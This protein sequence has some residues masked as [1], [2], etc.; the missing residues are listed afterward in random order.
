LEGVERLQ[1]RAIMARRMNICQQFQHE[2]EAG[3]TFL[4]GS[5][6]PFKQEYVLRLGNFKGVTAARRFA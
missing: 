2:H 3:R 5:A 1:S 4:C 6:K